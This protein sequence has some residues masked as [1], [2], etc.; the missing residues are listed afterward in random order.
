MTR[1]LPRLG[2]IQ[3]QI[4]QYLWSHKKATAREITNALNEI[5]PIAHSTV[6]TLLRKLEAKGTITHEIDDRTFLFRAVSGEDEVTENALRDL[7]GRVFHGSVYNLVSR[8]LDQE[9]VPP[10][11]LRRLRELID[12]ES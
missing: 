12:R 9:T 10:E 6:Q 7:L 8:L 3:L 11:E 4:M 2:K 1:P 5:Q